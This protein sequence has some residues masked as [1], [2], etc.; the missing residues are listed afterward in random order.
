MERGTE[1]GSLSGKAPNEAS[2][3]LGAGVLD[4]RAILAAAKRAGVKLYYI[5]DESPASLD[6]V[7]VSIA[8]LKSAGF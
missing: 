3:P 5:E 2:V 4:M 6:Q 8:W 7:P 1:T